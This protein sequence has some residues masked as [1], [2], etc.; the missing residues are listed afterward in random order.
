MQPAPIKIPEGS[1]VLALFQTIYHLQFLQVRPIYCLTIQRYFVRQHGD[2]AIHQ[3]NKALKELYLWCIDNRRT[4]Q[5]KKSEIILLSKT[6][7]ACGAYSTR[8][9]FFYWRLLC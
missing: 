6:S 8:F 4:L 2:Q 5:P 1:A 3:L 9:F 7:F